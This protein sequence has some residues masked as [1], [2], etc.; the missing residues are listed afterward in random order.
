[1]SRRLLSVREEILQT[2]PFGSAAEEAAVGLLL[3]ADAL[4]R[5]LAEV[6]EPSGITHQQYNVLRILR[7]A[8]PDAIQTLEIAERMIE[9]A[10]GITRLLDRLEDK[11]LVRRERGRPDRRCVHCRITP[12]GLALLAALDAPVA[13]ATAAAFGR[14]RRTE[15]VD[16]VSRLDRIRAALRHAAEARDAGARSAI[17]RK[18]ASP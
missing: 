18:G 15:I 1:M 10:P 11:G 6:I 14:W 13:A 2:R 4:A 7:G 9:Q 8:H 3:T 17:L 5:R 12:A 16:F